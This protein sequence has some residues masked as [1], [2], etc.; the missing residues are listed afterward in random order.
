VA[1]LKRVAIDTGVPMSELVR[2]ALLS[3]LA[4]RTAKTTEPA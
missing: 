4:E 3:Y 2:R 1:E